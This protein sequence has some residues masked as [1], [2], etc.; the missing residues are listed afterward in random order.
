MPITQSIA[1]QKGADNSVELNQILN[2]PNESPKK[3]KALFSIER[4]RI[5][6]DRN[7]AKDKV[8]VSGLIFLSMIA[9]PKNPSEIHRIVNITRRIN[10]GIGRLA[11]VFDKYV[12]RSKIGVAPKNIQRRLV[13][14]G[15][16]IPQESVQA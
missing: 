12:F 16:R 8:N 3:N 13:G 9:E 15:E 11:F 7:R 4:L 2:S 14:W 10:D 5:R 6:T 1:S